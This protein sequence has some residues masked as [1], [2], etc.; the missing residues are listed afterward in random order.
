MA[1]KLC[2]GILT[3]L[4]LFLG[5]V[6]TR[7]SLF[8]YERSGVIQASPETIFPYISNF[9]LGEHWSP[10]EKKDPAMKKTFIGPDAQVGSVMEFDGNAAAG[11]GK[12]ELLMLVPNERVQMKLF[13]TKPITAENLVEYTLT[14]E[15]GGGTRFTWTMSGDGGFMGKLVATLIDCEKLVA[16][17]FTVGINN[18]KELIEKQKI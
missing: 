5:Y 11:S 14:P 15:A 1:L 10:Y 3:A 16:D 13:M 4:V 12:I 7:T 17:D 8:R 9:R 2:L 6:S 18:L